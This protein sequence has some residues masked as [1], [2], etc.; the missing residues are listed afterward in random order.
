MKRDLRGMGMNR[1]GTDQQQKQQTTQPQQSA[2]EKQKL[3]QK[4]INNINEAIE[5]YGGKSETELMNELVNFRKQGIIDDAKL[6][7]VAARLTPML[8]AQQRKRLES[9]LGT[10]KST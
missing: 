9:V 1:Q 10:L 8:N 5:H 6:A 2:Y 4:D 3:P 7:D